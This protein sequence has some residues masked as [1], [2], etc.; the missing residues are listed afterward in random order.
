MNQKNYRL[1]LHTHSIISHDGGIKIDQ[2]RTLL[3]DPKIVIAI[4]DHNEISFAQKA[5]QD[6]GEKI[7]VGEEIMTIEGEI[8]GLF[9]KNRIEPKLSPEETIRQIRQQ[10][11]LVYIPHPLE[12][13]RRGLTLEVLRRISSS[14]DIVEIFNARTLESWKIKKVAE[15]LVGRNIIVA[16]SSDAHSVG[17]FGTAYSLVPGIP[18]REDIIELLK[19]AKLEN[20]PVP[21]LSR[22]APLINKI[23]KHKRL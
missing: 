17:G 1:D 23:K 11:G 21:F 10:N 7:I 8:I 12:K 2:Y 19:G 18:R 5:R 3:A 20:C 9:L 4:T 16:S 14:I 22:F 6:L 15:F 13:T